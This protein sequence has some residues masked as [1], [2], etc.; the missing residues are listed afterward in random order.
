MEENSS[1]IAEALMAGPL[2]T[3]RF[4]S[5][6]KHLIRLPR[7]PAAAGAHRG[8]LAKSPH[9]QQMGLMMA[10]QDPSEAGS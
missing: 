5:L 1:V 3:G 8:G 9:H 2:L 7:R 10:Q 6:L 4:L